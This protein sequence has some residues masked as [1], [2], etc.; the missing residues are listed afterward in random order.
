LASNP[1]RSIEDV[2]IND[3]ENDDDDDDDDYDDDDICDVPAGIG[4]DLA[5]NLFILT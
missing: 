2:I 4:L 3:D 1:A 5:I